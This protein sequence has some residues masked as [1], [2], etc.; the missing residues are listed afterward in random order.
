MGA[1]RQF[2]EAAHHLLGDA[3]ARAQQVPAQL[4]QAGAGRL[5]AELDGLQLRHLPQPGQLQGPDLGQIHLL[6][7]AD[8]IRQPP[9]QAVAVAGGLDLGHPLG[10]ALLGARRQAGRLEVEGRVAPAGGAVPGALGQAGEVA[11]GGLEKGRAQHGDAQRIRGLGGDRVGAPAARALGR[12]LEFGAE[13][14]EGTLAE[15]AAVLEPFAAHPVDRLFLP[16]QLEG[17]LAGP[18]HVKHRSVRPRG[19]LDIVERQV[20]R[21]VESGGVGQQRP[22]PLGRAVEVPVPGARNGLGHR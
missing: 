22:N 3:A 14:L 12:Q 17:T 11:P 4:Q 8:H 5:E 21:L 6:G 2:V 10:E 16:H 7:R 20:G 13:A 18:G 9:R 15:L 19:F 1:A